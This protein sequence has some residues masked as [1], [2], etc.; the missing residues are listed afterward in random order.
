MAMTSAAFGQAI[1]QKA[2]EI[3]AVRDPQLGAQVAIADFYGYFKDEGLDVTVR[4]LQSAAD[5]LT[6]MAGGDQNIG[7]GGTFTQIVFGGQKLPIKTIAPLADIAETQGNS[8]ILI[9]AKLAKTY[10]F[11]MA[12]VQLINMNPSEGIVAASK[13]EVQGMLGWQPNLYRIT[14]LGG[15]MYA[16]GVSMQKGGVMTALPFEDRLQYNHSTL[17]ASQK[18]IDEKPGV[19]KAVV[20]ALLKATALLEKDRPAALTA[21]E[22][23]AFGPMIKKKPKSEQR[24]IAAH[25]LA[26]VG[27][28][29]HEGKFPSEL[30]GGMKQRVAT[31][32]GA[33][34]AVFELD[35]PHP[36]DRSSVEFV[37]M[38]KKI[39]QMVREEVQKLGVS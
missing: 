24:K 19:L 22:N 32:P 29:G 37:T 27:L 30:S 18:W 20:K 7:T 16:T 15:S 36:R 35:L 26:M 23:V 28:A 2:I 4:W 8:Q 3:A 21:L 10:G 5:T 17:L 6:V 34:R 38:E 33:I 25:Y 11:D 13:G 9:L 14:T 1:E 31:R 12:K 39:K